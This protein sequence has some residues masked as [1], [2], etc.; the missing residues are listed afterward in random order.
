MVAEAMFAMAR[1]LGANA[2]VV[3]ELETTTPDLPLVLSARVGE[4]LLVTL[5]DES[6][7]Q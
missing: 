4:P 5:G 6:F 7:E 2:A 3:V 1:A